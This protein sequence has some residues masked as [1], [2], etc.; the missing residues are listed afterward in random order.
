MTT[1]KV[2]TLPVTEKTVCQT[3]A[4]QNRTPID[5][6]IIHTEVGTNTSADHRFNDCNSKVSAHYGVDLDGSIWHWVD[7]DWV[8]YHAG[9][10]EMNQRSIGIEHADNGLYNDPRPDSLYASSIALVAEICKFYSIPC[11][12]EH[13]LKHSEVVA[14]GCPDALDIDRIVKEAALLLNTVSVPSVNPIITDQTKLDT[15][16][17]GTL[18]WQAIKS[19]LS[20]RKT[21]ISNLQDQVNQKQAIID[22]LNHKITDMQNNRSVITG[23]NP[24]GS[25]PNLESG[26][27]NSTKVDPRQIS[28]I[29]T[30]LYSQIL[31]WIKRIKALFGKHEEKVSK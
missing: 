18:E 3:N 28:P 19:L 8:A 22:D 15:P 11:D 29:K 13:I 30:T 10:Y 17:D 9:N 4:D 12:R 16:S 14:T 21:S 23:Q 5:R 20:D 25:Y 1:R 7:E 27:N 2:T 24:D 26:V 31:E 6:I